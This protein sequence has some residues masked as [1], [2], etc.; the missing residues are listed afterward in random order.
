MY[1][2]YTDKLLE[3]ARYEK[4]AT[5]QAR[6]LDNAIFSTVETIIPP[7]RQPYL[8]Y[9]HY[10]SNLLSKHSKVLELCAG[11]GENTQILIKSSSNV[12]VTDIKSSF[13]YLPRFS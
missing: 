2:A 5:D 1:R 12:V 6:C 3:Q 13:R 10:I 8:D 9:N 7:L 4:R 11:M